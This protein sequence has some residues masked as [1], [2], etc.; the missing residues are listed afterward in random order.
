MAQTVFVSIK[1]SFCQ[2]NVKLQS[3][4]L[5]PISPRSLA[6]QMKTLGLLASTTPKSSELHTM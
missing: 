1:D 3:F 5:S 4:V 2:A 6:S